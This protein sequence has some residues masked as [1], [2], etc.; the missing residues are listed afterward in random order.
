MEPRRLSEKLLE[1]AILLAVSA[2]LIRFGLASLWEVRYPLMALIAIAAIAVLLWRL[3]Q[4][5]RHDKF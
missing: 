2:W 1:A 5:R 4:W 3:Y